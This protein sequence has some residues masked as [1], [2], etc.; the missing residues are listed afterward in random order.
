MIQ[1]KAKIEELEE[2]YDKALTEL[3]HGSYK[4]I[5]LEERIDKAIEYKVRIK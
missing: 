3:V 2:K 1:R 5:E 4:R